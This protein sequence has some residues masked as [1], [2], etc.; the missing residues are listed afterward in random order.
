MYSPSILIYLIKKESCRAYT[1]E[2]ISEVTL[3]AK[4]KYRPKSKE[5][6]RLKHRDVSDYL[7]LL[8]G[9]AQSNPP[10]G[11]YGNYSQAA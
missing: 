3:Q 4:Y 7:F 10:R 1:H 6:T 8:R 2:H 5:K 9:R 11:A